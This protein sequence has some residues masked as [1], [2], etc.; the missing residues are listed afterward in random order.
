MPRTIPL[1]VASLAAALTF[2]IAVAVA[3]FAP[4]SPG[5]ATSSTTATA[6]TVVTPDAPTVQ[7]DTVYVA[8]PPQQETITVHKVIKTSGE[9]GSE[10]E[11]QGDD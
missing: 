1:T 4:A 2:A 8:A 9:D 3:G 7:I 5:V 10:H 11:S 6:D